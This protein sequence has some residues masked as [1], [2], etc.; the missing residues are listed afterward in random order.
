VRVTLTRPEAVSGRRVEEVAELADGAL[1][2]ELL[3]QHGIDPRT[4]VV[5]V[6]G[7]AVTRGAA[8]RDGDQVRLYP[9][10]AGG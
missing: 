10:Q 8:L 7:A 9:V 4:C 3:D 6:N 1:A 5:V 2:G